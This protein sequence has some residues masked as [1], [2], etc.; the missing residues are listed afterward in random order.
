[1][2]R[3]AQKVASINLANFISMTYSTFEATLLGAELGI[4]SK[5]F[6]IKSRLFLLH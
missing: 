4:E 3:G 5:S 6:D 1:M 2:I